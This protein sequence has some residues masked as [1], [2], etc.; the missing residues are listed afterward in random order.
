MD[1]RRII[2]LICGFLVCFSCVFI[3]WQIVSVLDY[4]RCKD[5]V[6]DICKVSTEILF[7]PE[8]TIS[9][10]IDTQSYLAALI[11]IPLAIFA[12]VINM[13]F[14]LVILLCLICIPL[15][16]CNLIFYGLL[17]ENEGQIA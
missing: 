17:A 1:N 10:N 3:C 2:S 14:C 4:Y 7:A 6:L 5:S 11:R 8:L 12:F 13:F 9:I 16:A 15:C